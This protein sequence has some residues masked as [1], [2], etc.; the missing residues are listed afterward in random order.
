[1]LFTANRVL[2]ADRKMIIFHFQWRRELLVFTVTLKL[3]AVDAMAVCN[4]SSWCNDSEWFTGMRV[5]HRMGAFKI[6]PKVRTEIVDV[7]IMSKINVYF[8]NIKKLN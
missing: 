2:W 5:V 1:M 6:A 7:S 4:D 3:M 8:L